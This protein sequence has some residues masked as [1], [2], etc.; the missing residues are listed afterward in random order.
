MERLLSDIKENTPVK[1]VRILES[2]DAIFNRL[3]EYGLVSG[4]EIKIIKIA[5]RSEVYLISV[6]GFAL[7]VDKSTCKKVV[8]CE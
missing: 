1:V 4:E 6:R 8:V 5:P 7:C 3:E 2:N